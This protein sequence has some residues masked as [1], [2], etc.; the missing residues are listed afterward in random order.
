MKIYILVFLA[1][2]TISL[3]ATTTI[4]STNH[5]AYGANV[6]WIEM[7]GDDDSGA[8]IGESYCTGYLYSANCG[9]ICLGNTTPT[10]GWHYSNVSSDDWGVN[11]DG[12]G[13]LT[14]YAYGANIGWI[15][16]EQ[17]HGN[18]QVDMVTGNLNG[19]IWSANVGWISLINAQAHVQTDT[20]ST[21]PDTDADGIPDAWEYK[22][23]GKLNILSATDDLDS[24]GATDLSEY[25]ADTDPDDATDLLEVFLDT[26]VGTN[27]LSWA[28]HVTR[29]YRL[30]Y[31]DDLQD[32]Q[33]SNSASGLLIDK[34][35]TLSIDD[36]PSSDVPILFYRV[37]AIRP[38]SE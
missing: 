12:A 18:P 36:T 14:G 23:Y 7:R 16:F 4:N 13:T 19:S 27:T 17:I 10:N 8:I 22:M 30:Q 15:N 11:H 29:H 21:G 31:T 1:L 25:M 5:N 9:W 6:G 28:T 33:W 26:T 24:D 37:K 35:G 32:G 20:I 3:Q 38:L 2:S 34:S